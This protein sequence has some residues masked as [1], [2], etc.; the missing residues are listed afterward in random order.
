MFSFPLKLFLK[1]RWIWAGIATAVFLN[2]VSWFYL[3]LGIK[4]TAESVFLHYTINFGVDLAGPWS[5]IFFLP[6]LGLF[7]ALLNFFLAYFLYDAGSRN[8]SRLILAGTILLE[9][10]LLLESFSL[11]FLNH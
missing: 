2:L 1:D 7:L 11:V 10:F 4:T 5:E 9:F 8:L 6:I 3:G